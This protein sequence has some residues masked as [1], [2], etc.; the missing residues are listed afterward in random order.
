MVA[1]YTKKVNVP[2][3][4]NHLLQVANLD[5]LANYASKMLT[6]SGVVYSGSKMLNNE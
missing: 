3:D 4:L 2:Y 6:T 1:K 5:D